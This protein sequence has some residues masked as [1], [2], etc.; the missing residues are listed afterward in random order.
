MIASVFFSLLVQKN[1][2]FCIVKIGKQISCLLSIKFIKVI[3]LFSFIHKFK[4]T[5][6][7]VLASVKW[8]NR[9]CGLQWVLIWCQV[10]TNGSFN[11]KGF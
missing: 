6:A 10:G 11:A 2:V 5:I 7:A 8:S 9:F 4:E 1:L 3:V